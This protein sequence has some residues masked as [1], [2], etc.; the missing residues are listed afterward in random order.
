MTPGSDREASRAPSPRFRAEV[1]DP[2]SRAWDRIAPDV[3][4]IEREQF[5]EGAFDEEYLADEFT[6]PEN[7]AV[8]LIDT[9]S[10]R[11]AGFT[12]AVP[13]SLKG[14]AHSSDRK[15]GAYVC[16]TALDYDHQ[17]RA[18]VGAMMIVLEEQLRR[19]GYRYLERDAAVEN[20]YAA[21]IE[22]A[23]AGRIVTQGRPR[24]SEYGPQV[25]FR[26]DLQIR[27]TGS[28]E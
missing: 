25:F 12:F 26:I 23:Y 27:S 19:R 14:W 13:A 8:V 7:T 17:G 9:V 3:M 6:D 4:R 28:H 15:D 21:K 10:E 16:D 18:L 1:Y 2:Q 5:G 22:R 11:V 20:G 24:M